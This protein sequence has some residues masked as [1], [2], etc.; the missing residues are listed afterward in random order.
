MA[1]KKKAPSHSPRAPRAPRAP[2]ART[3][4]SAK[5]WDAWLAKNHAKS[6]GVWI[7]IAKAKSGVKSVTYPEALDVALAWGWIDGQKKGLDERAWLQRFTPRGARSIWSKI[8]CAKALALI[9]SGAM[10]PAGR[11]E[12]E[13]AKAD[14]RWAQA[15]DSP[16]AAAIPPDLAEALATNEEAHAF[17]A[18]LDSRNRY[19][20]LFRIQTAKKA[21]T[22][23]ARIAKFVAMMA[24][25]ERIHA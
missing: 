1:A 25:H 17:F 14:G 13:R 23:A 10:Q 19:A 5:A 11:A 22:R 8:N 2:L 21:E 20:V 6:T 4:A 15:Y 24:R 16:R 7:E 3:F 18:S 12:V 9:E